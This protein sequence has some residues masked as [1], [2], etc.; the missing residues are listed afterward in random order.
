ME[1][2]TSGIPYSGK[3]G[4]K[5]LALMTQ[6]WQGQFLR[7]LPSDAYSTSGSRLRNDTEERKKLKKNPVPMPRA[8]R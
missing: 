1:S 7:Q 3:P 5:F 2:R 4:A 8:E 6:A